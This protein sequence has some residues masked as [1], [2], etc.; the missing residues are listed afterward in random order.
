MVPT[1]GPSVSKTLTLET[2]AEGFTRGTIFAG[3]YEILEGLGSG[4][5]GSVYRVFDRKLEEEVALKVVRPEI[6]VN[7]KAIERFKNELKVA[8]KIAHKAVCKMYDLGE[9]EGTSYI[10][11]EYV[12]GEDLRSFIHRSKQLTVATSVSIGCQVAEGLSEAHKLGI[13]HRDLKPGNIMIDKEGNA[14]I[15]DF[16]IARSLLGKGLTVE[17]AIIG[18]PEYMS[19]EQV[20]GKEADQRSDIYSLGVIFYEMVTGRVP[21]EGDT[22]LNIALMHKTEIPR[23]PR[24]FNPQLPDDF[25][26]IILRCLEKEKE[27]RYQN[28]DELLSD[29]REV[30]SETTPAEKPFPQSRRFKPKRTVA[31]AGKAAWKKP[32]AIGGAAVLLGLIITAGILLLPGRGEMIDSIAVLPFKTVNVDPETE[33]LCDGIAQDLTDKLQE[34]SGMKKVIPFTT[35]L[36]YKDQDAGADKIG[37]ELRVKA[38]LM[39]RMTHLGDR[40]SLRPELIKTED[41]SLILG[42]TYDQPLKNSLAFQEDIMRRLV[43]RLRLKLSDEDKRRIT[44]RPIDNEQAYEYYLKATQEIHK[45]TKE[46]CDRA[47]QYLQKGLDLVGD[48]AVLYAGL[49]YVHFQY[50]NIAVSV[51][52]NMNKAEEYA[53]KAI[54]LDPEVPEAQ[55]ILGLLQWGV[56][57]DLGKVLFHFKKALARKPNDLEI[58]FWTCGVYIDLGKMSSGEPLLK[59]MLEIDPFDLQTQRMQMLYF[60]WSG[61]LDLWAEAISRLRD[62]HPELRSQLSWQYARALAAQNRI[63]EALK[64]LAPV[65]KNPQEAMKDLYSNFALLFECAL[66]MD[67]KAFLAYLTPDTVEEIKIDT[68]NS[69]YLA[70]DFA[71]LKDNENALFWLENAVKCGWINYPFLNEYDPFLKNIRSDE[72]FQKLMARVKELWENFKE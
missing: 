46:G 25:S 59:R 72:R 19:P 48:N 68:Q 69:I 65:T 15:M 53:K 13:I 9:S 57:P 63:E 44:E 10:T 37:R 52:E 16:G 22:P 58:L 5:M 11:M 14:K 71:L 39:T 18:T 51:K 47:A 30:E 34:L 55:F 35:A 45:F 50:S 21:F 42:Q 64:I 7:R 38:V 49:A 29:L 8:R 17:G 1:E 41:G 33:L 43:S 61:R 4:G 36:R 3:R 70:D 60:Y 56:T 28:T 32:A 62:Q 27:K 23:D 31:K 54:A 40:V 2:E 12:T 67:R 66:R 24:E 20:E 6:A 26:E